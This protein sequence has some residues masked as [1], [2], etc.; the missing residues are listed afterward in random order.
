[1]VVRLI[2]ECMSTTSYPFGADHDDRDLGRVRA[3]LH[4]HGA[5]WH[6]RRRFRLLRRRQI[7]TG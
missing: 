1:M 6:E 5:A 3:D 7:G 4:A 2:M